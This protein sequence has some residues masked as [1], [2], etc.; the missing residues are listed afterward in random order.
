MALTF[1]LD[2]Y[3]PNGRLVHVQCTGI[4]Y[5]EE[6]GDAS[7]EI[8]LRISDVS[9]PNAFYA[10]LAESTRISADQGR[11]EVIGFRSQVLEIP[12]LLDIQ[13]P[14]PDPITITLP[15]Q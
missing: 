12:R 1:N 3:W 11:V 9:S 4:A 10:F 14:P 6:R 5:L 15:R 13:G 2:V 8:T 7:R